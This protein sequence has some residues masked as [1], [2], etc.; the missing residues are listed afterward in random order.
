[1]ATSRIELAA[2][3]TA[4]EQVITSDYT[5]LDRAERIVLTN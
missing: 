5:S 3:A 4:G 1:M 2:N